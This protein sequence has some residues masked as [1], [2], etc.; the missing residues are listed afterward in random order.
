MSDLVVVTGA[1]SG[2]G[3]ACVSVFEEAGYE[4]LGVDRESESDAL[5][6]VQLDLSS[7]ECG[8]ILNDVLD[9]EPV[10]GLVNNA[11]MGWSGRAVD[12]SAEDFDQVMNVN[13][14]A[15]FLLA[16]ALQPELAR[17]GGFVVNVASVHAVATSKH[18][19]AY[20]ASKGGLVALTRALAVEW[21][22][23]IRVNAVLPGAI[24]T[25]MLEEGLSRI[26]TTLEEMGARHLLGNVGA[27]S[28]IASA[29]LFLARNTFATG[30]LVT[31]DGGATAKL[32]TE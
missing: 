31:V 21:A 7:P 4:V 6:H 28:D 32:S 15:P 3:K 5:R 24:E 26:G 23:H 29:V 9:G 27:A 10:K 2:I 30:S 13:L 14:R 18:A 20:V 1:S 22:P 12:I 11:A 17:H 25:P 16:S 8:R 19:S